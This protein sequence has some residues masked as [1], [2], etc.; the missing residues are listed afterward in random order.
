MG[1]SARLFAFASASLG[2]LSLAYGISSLTGR[3]VP[4]GMAWREI[5]IY[6]SGALAVLAAAGLCYRRTAWPSA[7]SIGAYLGIWALTL[8]PQILAKP[9]SF[10]GWYGFC[11]ALSALTGAWILCVTLSPRPTGRSVPLARAIFALTCL[12]YGASHFAYAD[13]TAGM[14]PPWLPGH[15]AWAYL[16]GAAH[17]AAGLGILFGIRAVLAATLEALMMSLFGL[18]VWVPS[19]FAH[20]P[21]PWAGPPVN[22]WSELVVSLL[23]AAAAWVIVASYAPVRDSLAPR[24]RLV[25]VGR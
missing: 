4:G 22:Q 9:L 25:K 18:L 8:T 24:K 5:W 14:V 16:T 13:Y 17:L 12:F 21:P 3:S 23:L 11:E 2:L 1:A 20:P 19:F 6:A 10:E 15:L 7:V